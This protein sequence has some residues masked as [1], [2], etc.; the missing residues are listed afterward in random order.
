MKEKR[1]NKIETTEDGEKI[2]LYWSVYDQTWR[3][4]VPEGIPDEELAA[5]ESE[6]REEILLLRGK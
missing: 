1:K 4:S 6:E 5:M 3:T 2:V